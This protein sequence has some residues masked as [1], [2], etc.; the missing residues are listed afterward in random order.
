[1]ASGD[2]V[3]KSLLLAGMFGVHSEGS[4]LSYSTSHSF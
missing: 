4:S 2:V 3:D 1:M